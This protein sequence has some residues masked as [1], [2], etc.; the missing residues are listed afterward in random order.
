MNPFSILPYG[1]EQRE[2]WDR[3]VMEQSANGTFLQT[4]RFLS[5]QFFR[6]IVIKITYF[7]LIFLCK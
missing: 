4:R 7:H 5:Y 2:R 6:Q 3:F 1:E